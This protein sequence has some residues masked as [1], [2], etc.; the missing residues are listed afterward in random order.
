MKKIVEENTKLLKKVLEEKAKDSK[1]RKKINELLAEVEAEMENNPA[2]VELKKIRERNSNNRDLKNNNKLM[3]VITDLDF[4]INSY[5]RLSSNSGIHTKGTNPEDITDGKSLL[6]FK[7]LSEE[8]KKGNFK[9]STTK[10][11]YIPKPGKTTKRPLG[12]PNLTD[13]I[14]QDLI[15]T[16]L[17]EIYEPLFEK[18]NWN[19]GFRPKKGCLT[20]MDKIKNEAKGMTT[21]IEGDI[22][23]AYDNV[24]HK[25]LMNILKK[26]ISDQRF[27][28]LIKDGLEAQIMDNGKVL[29]SITGVPQGGIASPILFNVYMHE[30]DVFITNEMSNLFNEINLKEQRNV[31]YYGTES[32]KHHKASV[33]IEKIRRHIRA[34]KKQK[35]IRLGKNI[36]LDLENKLKQRQ[37][38][39]EY[40]KAVSERLHTNPM[41]QKKRV[42][43]GSYTRYADDWII[44]T[45]AN[46][47]ICKILKDKAQQWLMEN[48]K[49]ELSEEKTV[50][51]NLFEGGAKF[52]GFKIH[53]VKTNT[54]R[55][56]KRKIGVFREQRSIP[57]LIGIDLDR[58]HSKMVLQKMLKKTQKGKYVP[59]HTP[60]FLSQSNVDI[61]ETYKKK[62][63]GIMNYYY[64]I[65]DYKSKLQYIHYL[66]NMSLLKTLANKEKT[67][68]RNIERK[69]TRKLIMTQNFT[70]LNKRTGKEQV[71]TN[72]T[73][74]P[75]YTES[76]IYAEQIASNDIE[77]KIIWKQAKADNPI[78]QPGYIRPAQIETKDSITTETYFPSREIPYYHSA[79]NSD[80]FHVIKHRTRT[81]YNLRLK[82]CPI[83]KKT[84]TKNNPIEMHHLTHLK[85]KRK[86]NAK[87]TYDQLIG[88]LKSKQIPC[89]QQCH[90][91]I[92]K[93]Q[94]NG[95]NLR[96]IYNVKIIL[97]PE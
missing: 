45:N 43:M 21:A 77:K 89:C 72:K 58:I 27:L 35:L 88:T 56:I 29:H 5:E 71:T 78:L 65:I 74:F 84:A 48:L 34:F 55:K 87:L 9:W 37:L 81:A 76:V 39:K 2:F 38:K 18:Y 52:L 23:G 82:T 75:T 73:F 66:F 22:K 12:I 63:I 68:M 91:K 4:I 6:D 44:L 49:L 50:I 83:C 67:T 64:P 93:G 10:R 14:V 97:D 7:N 53:R 31:E 15:R 30:F 36:P 85:H 13:K 19:H 61:V 95:D 47:S 33:K 96:E 20:A 42:L 94:Y 79:G 28:K 46:E 40:R 25:I 11:I 90:N 70:V 41:S 92:H 60:H 32:E 59:T 54:I 3:K 51:T 8:L 1:N 69:Y 86:N 26:K 24:D 57:T 80:P 62:I 17:E 16:I